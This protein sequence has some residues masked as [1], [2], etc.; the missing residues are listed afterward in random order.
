MNNKSWPLQ[1]QPSQRWPPSVVLNYR[2]SILCLVCSP[3]SLVTYHTTLNL[4][5]VS[6]DKWNSIFNGLF[7]CN[8]EHFASYLIYHIFVPKFSSAYTFLSLSEQGE[9]FRWCAKRTTEFNIS[10]FLNITPELDLKKRY[11]NFSWCNC[12]FG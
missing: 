12:N 10:F 3:D 6:F 7:Y 11:R 1:F 4:L 5:N 8:H 2:I 9:C